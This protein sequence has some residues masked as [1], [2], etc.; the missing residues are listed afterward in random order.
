MNK[1]LYRVLLV[2]DEPW[3]RDILRNLGDW[4]EL[5]LTV[6]GEAE[7]GEQ[8]IQLVKQRSASHYHYGHAHARHR[9]CGAV[10]DA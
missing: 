6:A 3:N 5:G 10:A 1:E 2:D 8:A 7:D 4:N 9:R